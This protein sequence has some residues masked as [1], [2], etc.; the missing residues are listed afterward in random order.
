MV[1]VSLRDGTI[2]EKYNCVKLIEVMVGEQ[3]GE[4]WNVGNVVKN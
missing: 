4:K 2:S 1:L 3:G